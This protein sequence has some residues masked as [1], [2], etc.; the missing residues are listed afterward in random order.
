MWQVIG[1]NLIDQLIISLFAISEDFPIAPS[2]VH[3]NLFLSCN[4]D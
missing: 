3:L 1:S 4:F 2:L